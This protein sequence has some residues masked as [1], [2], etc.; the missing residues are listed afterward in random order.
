MK[1]HKIPSKNGQKVLVKASG[2]RVM[3]G[4]LRTILRLTLFTT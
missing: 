3:L 1:S 2:I 4:I